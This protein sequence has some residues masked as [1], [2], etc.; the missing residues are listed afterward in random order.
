MITAHRRG[1]RVA[2]LAAALAVGMSPLAACEPVEEDLVQGTPESPQS[3]QGPPEDLAGMIALTDAAADEWVEGATV[4]EVVVPQD[5]ETVV[6]VT[7][8]APDTDRMLVVEATDDGLVEQQPTFETLG[9]SELTATA[10]D[11][12]PDPEGVL[13]PDELPGA[14]EET[15]EACGVEKVDELLYTTG[16]PAAWDGAQWTSEP[17]WEITVLGAS[18]DGAVLDGD[19]E[20]REDPCI[21][22]EPVS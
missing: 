8:V 11:A 13:D 15:L 6:R 18:G 12:V 1:V 2:L 3:G 17:A 7:Y 21:V 14:A 16:A 10:L 9:F 5:A 22:V 19:G 4:V 20:P